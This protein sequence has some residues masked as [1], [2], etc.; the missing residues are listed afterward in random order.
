MT[1]RFVEG[2]FAVLPFLEK[3][4]LGNLN[5][6]TGDYCVNYVIPGEVG[7]GFSASLLAVGKDKE[8]IL[9]A[10]FLEKDRLGVPTKV[11]IFPTQEVEPNLAYKDSGIVIRVALLGKKGTV[12]KVEDQYGR[13]QDGFLA[14]KVWDVQEGRFIEVA[15]RKIDGRWWQQPGQVHLERLYQG[16]L[17]I[18]PRFKP[19]TCVYI[20]PIS[21]AIN[22]KSE[23]ISQCRLD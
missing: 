23:A 3:S 22:S 9:V 6:P 16:G 8:D 11:E 21:E 13:R 7:L 10:R 15:P 2:S 18:V 17:L 20:F 14:V 12:L 1:P 19:P 5:L 4:I